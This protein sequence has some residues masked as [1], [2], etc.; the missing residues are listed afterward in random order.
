MEASSSPLLHQVR[1][2]HFNEKGRWALDYKGVPHRRRSYQP[3]LH[4]LSSRR[5]GGGGTMPILEFEDRTVPD[6]AA[7]VAELERIAPD[8]HLYPSDGAERERALSL[9]QWLGEGLGPGVRS[10][11][12]HELLP[13]GRATREL[14]MQGFSPAAKA[15]NAALF[16]V[17]R[18][19]IRRG[20]KADGKGAERGRRQTVEAMDRIESEL[21][22]S[23]YLV[24]DSFSVADLTGAALLAPLVAPPG[25]GYWLPDRWPEGW[26]EF[27][28]ELRDR[29][30][31]AWTEEMYRRHRGES[32]EVT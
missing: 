4:V 10:A 29:D 9:E 2:S 6:S 32:A 15:F 8:P 26:E 19:A 1:F 20:L 17:G 13:D 24:G 5:L 12:F 25:F 23:D 11:I 14:T 18:I 22:G 21:S 30:A 3:G 16:P 28:S 31:W 27:R 7:I